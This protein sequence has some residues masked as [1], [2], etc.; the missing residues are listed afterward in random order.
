[1]AC[2]F[3]NFVN[4]HAINSKNPIH[5]NSLLSI[6][7]TVENWLHSWDHMQNLSVKILINDLSAKYIPRK[8]LCIW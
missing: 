3:C 6:I 8:F 1:M 2:S 5:E 4:D 7:S